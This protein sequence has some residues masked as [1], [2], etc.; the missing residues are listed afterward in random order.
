M[1]VFHTRH[2]LNVY[3]VVRSLRDIFQLLSCQSIETTTHLH[4]V[5]SLPHDMLLYNGLILGQCLFTSNFNGM[6]DTQCCMVQYIHPANKLTITVK[7][8]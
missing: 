3:T 7:L 5:N 6:C 1:C 2:G 4:V 8:L